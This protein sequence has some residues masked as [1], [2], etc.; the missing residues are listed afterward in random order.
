MIL[1]NVCKHTSIFYLDL[2]KPKHIKC[3]GTAT[4]PEKIFFF[5]TTNDPWIWRDLIIRLVWMEYNPWFNS[6]I[7]FSLSLSQACKQW[8]HKILKMENEHELNS[9]KAR[10][11]WIPAVLFVTFDLL[12]L[13]IR[14]MQNKW[15]NTVNADASTQGKE[16]A[17]SCGGFLQVL[18]LPLT[19][20][21]VLWNYILHVC[22]CERDWLFSSPCLLC[23][24][25][26]ICPQLW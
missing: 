7:Q 16:F 13:Q 1:R 2:S 15:R 24:R 17:C 9:L 4:Q 14:R 21:S 8:S 20:R 11:M 6:R 5:V 19:V 12:Y 22:E 25:L 18:W 26:A 10:I 23:D 3:M